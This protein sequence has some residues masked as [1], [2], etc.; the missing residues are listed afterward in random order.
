MRLPHHRGLNKVET[1]EIRLIEKSDVS[2]V[3]E[4]MADSFHNEALYR[5]FV[6]DEGKR[7]Q[8]LGKFLAFV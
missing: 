4:A 1:M 8:F 3:A 7:E 6:P 5:Y 2:K